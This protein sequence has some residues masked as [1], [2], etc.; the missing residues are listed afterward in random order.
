MKI[1]NSIITTNKQT[2]SPYQPTAK[3]G[4]NHDWHVFGIDEGGAPVRDYIRKW[5]DEQYFRYQDIYEKEG[6]MSEYELQ[7]TISHL[8]Q[9]P[10]VVDNEMLNQLKIPALKKVEDTIYRGAAL[11]EEKVNRVNEAGI[12]R[13]IEIGLNG[14]SQNTCEKL[15][16]DYLHS[17]YMN[18]EYYAAL[19]PKK[20]VESEAR[21]YA[22]D[23][24]QYKE[25]DIEKYV[26]DEMKDWQ[27]R[28]R[29]FIDPFVRFIQMMQKGNVYLGCVNGVDD[30]S[31]ILTADYL[32]NPKMQHSIPRRG[33]SSDSIIDAAEGLYLNLTKDDK[34]KMGWTKAFDKEFLP[35]VEKLINKRFG[36]L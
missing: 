6:R 27:R 18:D 2:S 23:V 22:R 20:Y 35:K 36:I 21:S 19:N 3:G 26:K 12:K 29:G 15:G 5:R 30:T 13:L 8:V 28:S 10:Q 24:L 1:H 17:P 31:A 4:Y 16:M 34:L 9:K 25:K 32:F 11:S 33:I 7:R 14:G